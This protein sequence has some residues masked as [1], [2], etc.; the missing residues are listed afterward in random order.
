MAV[1][2]MWLERTSGGG[3]PLI[4]LEEAKDTL[5]IISPAGEIPELDA[6]ISRAIAAAS[7]VLDVDADG[8]GGLGFP[9]T[10]Q[11]WVR[12]GSCFSDGFL[13]LPFARITSVDAL[14]YLDPSGATATV[15][16]DG[17]AL[18]GRG[19]S[20]H[21]ALVGGYCWPAVAD[22]PDAVSLEFTAGF[23]SVAAVPEDIR[24]AVCEL[25]KLYYDHPLADAALGVPRQVQEGIDRLTHRYR[26]FAI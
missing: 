8:F 6:Q 15:P 26:A 16:V 10:S 13:H 12:K 25:V 24:A 11:T 14:R 18:V 9:L 7:T 1:R 3:V 17:Y 5:R 21:V 4:S 2:A 19:R 22:R 20:R 23:A